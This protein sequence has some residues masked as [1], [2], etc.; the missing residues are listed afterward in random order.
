MEGSARGHRDAWDHQGRESGT[1]SPP[2]GIEGA[3]S[4]P[5]LPS[6]NAD[7]SKHV[8]KPS[9]SLVAQRRSNRGSASEYVWSWMVGRT[10]WACVEFNVGYLPTSLPPNL[11]ARC[12]SFGPRARPRP[13]D[14]GCVCRNGRERGGRE[15]QRE[16]DGAGN[17]SDQKFVAKARLR[18]RRGPS[19]RYRRG[20]L[21]RSS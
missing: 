11:R 7:A 20:E 8:R 9:G 5:P 12:S 1:P 4:Y 15:R 6:L 17:N 16:S 2:C 13:P 19:Q 18:R 14:H 10:G 3:C 21:A